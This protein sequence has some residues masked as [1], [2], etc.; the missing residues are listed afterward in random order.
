MLCPLSESGAVLQVCKQGLHVR[1]RF[2]KRQNTHTFESLRE[3]EA[4][5]TCPSSLCCCCGGVCGSSLA[6]SFG[7]AFALPFKSQ[8]CVLTHRNQ[9]SWLFSASQMRRPRWEG[10]VTESL[11][12]AGLNWVFSLSVVPFPTVSSHRHLLSKGGGGRRA[13]E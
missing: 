12:V 1:V 2:V 10:G 3:P 5:I 13:S 11:E 9:H 8:V 6:S 4:S 7:F